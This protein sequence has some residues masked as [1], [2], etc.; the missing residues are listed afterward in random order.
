MKWFLIATAICAASVATHSIA[1]EGG[2]AG[3]QVASDNGKL[4]SDQRNELSPMSE[5]AL[6]F[7]AGEDVESPRI[8]LS[9]RNISLLEAIEIVAEVAGLK[10]RIQGNVVVVVPADAPDGE[11]IHRIYDVVPTIVERV[12]DVSKD[13]RK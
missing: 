7:A 8:T 9:A 6:R 10:H 3:V 4:P 1:S 5:K 2:T 11:I 13:L 12:R